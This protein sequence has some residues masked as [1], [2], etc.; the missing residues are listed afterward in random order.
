MSVVLTFLGGPLHLDRKIID[1]ATRTYRHIVVTRYVGAQM[2]IETVTHTYDLMDMNQAG[3]VL[4]LYRGPTGATCR[5]L[6]QEK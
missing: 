4:Y 3:E 5:G 1:S 6:S 2:P